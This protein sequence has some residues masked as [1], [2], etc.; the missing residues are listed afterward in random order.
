MRQKS[1]I[2]ENFIRELKDLLRGVTYGL[3]LDEGVFK[4]VENQV[5]KVIEEA[6]KRER[7]EARMSEIEAFE[8]LFKAKNG[9]VYST[10]L[11]T[12]IQQRKELTNFLNG[13]KE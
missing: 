1:E 9:V 11:E 8:D 13:Q 2:V 10:Q 4:A 7:T 3:I 5:G 12:L 6:A